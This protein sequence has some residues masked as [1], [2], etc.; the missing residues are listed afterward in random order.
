MGGGGSGLMV[1]TIHS[2]H[3]FLWRKFLYVSYFLIIKLK[4]NKNKL[5]IEICHKINNP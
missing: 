5:V 1:N 3:I 4:T 2:I